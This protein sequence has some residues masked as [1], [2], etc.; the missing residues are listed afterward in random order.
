MVTRRVSYLPL[1]W[2]LAAACSTTIHYTEPK[3]LPPWQCFLLSTDT[4]PPVDVPD[5]LVMGGN[6][7]GTSI[8][9]AAEV[10]PDRYPDPHEKRRLGARWYPLAGDSVYIEWY[11]PSTV[12]GPVGVLLAVRTP[13][14]LDGHAAH[15]S[16][17]LPLGPWV[18]IN[19][20]S[21]PCPA[22]A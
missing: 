14:S 4:I 12:F 7:I 1:L 20:R 5:T 17:A 6:R 9:F 13:S 8:W 19:G 21:I 11:L 10:R 22:G 18:R 16:D 15:G 3:P 2:L